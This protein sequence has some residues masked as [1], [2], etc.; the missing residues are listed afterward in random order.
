[1]ASLPTIDPAIRKYISEKIEQAGRPAEDYNIVAVYKEMHDW[2]LRY[3]TDAVVSDRIEANVLSLAIHQFETRDLT[4]RIEMRFKDSAN[5]RRGVETW[6]QR[7]AYPSGR[8]ELV[9][10]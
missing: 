4:R 1:M 2:L 7:A 3:Q 9:K 5:V 6:F 10:N 8:T